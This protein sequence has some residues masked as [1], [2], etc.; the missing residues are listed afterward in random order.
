MV[1][2]LRERSFTNNPEKAIVSGNDL[3]VGSSYSYAVKDDFE[4]SYPE[5]GGDDIRFGRFPDELGWEFSQ[6]GRRRQALIR[7]GIFTR[8][9]WLSHQR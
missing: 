9:S 3:L 4:N 2:K 7:F 1:T 6:E 8:K 5:E